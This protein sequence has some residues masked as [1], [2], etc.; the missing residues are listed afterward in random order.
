MLLIKVVDIDLNNN[1]VLHNQADIWP[2]EGVR[3]HFKYNLASFENFSFLLVIT[4]EKKVTNKS[5]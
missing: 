5:C 2:L 3:A 1:F 4:L